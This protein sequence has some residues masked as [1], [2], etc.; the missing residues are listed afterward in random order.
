MELSLLIHNIG[1]VLSVI[2]I[3]ILIGVVLFKGKGNR[4]SLLLI[5]LSGGVL[6]FAL[7][8]V[9]GVN[10]EDSDLSRKVLLFNSVNA[11]LSIFLAHCVISLFEKEKEQKWS[12]VAIYGFGIGIFI[13]IL[14][15]LDLFLLQSVPKMYFPNYYEAGPLYILLV[16]YSLSVVAYVIYQS[17]KNLIESRKGDDPVFYNRVKYVA[18]GISIGVLFGYQAFL[19]VMNIQV[20]PIWSPLHFIYV[21]FFVY[22]IV[23]YKLFD[24]NVIAQNALLYS[25]FIAVV[26]FFIGLISY[27]NIQLTETYPQLSHWAIPLIS[28]LFAL[29]VGQLVWKKIR[30]ADVLKYE[31]T[32]IISH[33]FRTPLTRIKWAADQ[34]PLQDSQD[35]RKDSSKEIKNSAD[36]LIEL[37]N[38]LITVSNSHRFNSSKHEL[39]DLSRLIK[40]EIVEKQEDLEKMSLTLNT[41]IRDGVNVRMDKNRI[42]FVIKVL[43]TNAL[44]Y[45]KKD[46][47]VDVSLQV[48][49]KNK[50]VVFEVRDTGLGIDKEEKKYMFKRFFRGDRS[51]LKDTEGLGIDLSISKNI[52][53]SVG[54]DI[55]FY[56]EGKD[57]GSTFTVTLP[58]K[59]IEVAINN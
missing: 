11:I 51:R 32:N 52:I 19:L 46:G 34:I 44:S 13:F 43:L 58:W 35:E 18:T 10:I 23:K 2:M 1:Y 57:K 42:N 45:N 28:S 20:D 14:M 21:P 26:T 22:A 55:S 53:D 3:L 38:M 27:I 15:N 4:Q 29:I 40:N 30:Q 47:S 39:V 48:L 56:S 24:I 6:V 9:I 33:K 5:L 59:I 37:T 41:S 50:K 16:T 25:I 31:F 7:S 17:V 12:L 36:S 54:G 8:H 49:E